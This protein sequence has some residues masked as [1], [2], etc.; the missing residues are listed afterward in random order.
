MEEIN[1]YTLIQE[2][3]EQEQKEHIFNFLYEN[4]FAAIR[5]CLCES[6]L[7]PGTVIQEKHLADTLHVSRTPLRQALSM[8]TESGLLN[9]RPGGGFI[10]P[11]LTLKAFTDANFARK[12]FETACAELAACN[13]SAEDLSYLKKQLIRMQNF[14]FATT[15]YENIRTFAEID[16]NFH[17]QICLA[18]KNDYLIKAYQELKPHLMHM[19][20]QTV[21][22]LSPVPT[23]LIVTSV[24]DEH[25]TIY[26]AIRNKDPEFAYAAT[27]IHLNNCRS[28][29]GL[30]QG[31]S[32]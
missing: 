10:V 5:R 2:L 4:I 24:R 23:K 7:P 31:N 9:P 25:L 13:A 3:F 19:R 6:L 14:K 16:M 28:V 1:P 30:S 29:W 22:E 18:S 32:F 11:K 20:Y 26:M 27:R 21:Y 17:T 8:L 12:A 15:E